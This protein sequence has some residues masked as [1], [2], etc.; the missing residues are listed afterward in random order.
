[1]KWSQIYAR[2]WLNLVPFMGVFISPQIFGTNSLLD[3]SGITGM[4][5][6]AG[7][8]TIRMQATG[9]A[10]LDLS[11]LASIANATTVLAFVADGTNS[12][13]DLSSLTPGGYDAARVTFTET[14]GGTIILPAPLAADK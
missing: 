7:A 3:L 8:S 6:D 12:T 9:G 1:M 10:T 4:S 14:N 5:I 13:I 2:K 11:S